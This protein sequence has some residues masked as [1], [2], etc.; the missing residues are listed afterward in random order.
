MFCVHYSFVI[1]STQQNLNVFWIRTRGKETCWAHKSS[2]ER[3]RA[4]LAPCRDLQ[5]FTFGTERLLDE[6]IRGHDCVLGTFHL[7][8]IGKHPHPKQT[9]VR[10]NVRED[11][12]SHLCHL[13]RVCKHEISTFGITEKDFFY[14]F[15]LCLTGKP[16]DVW[17]HMWESDNGTRLSLNQKMIRLNLEPGPELWK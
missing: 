13:Q 1:S 6:R 5:D 2:N 16:E 10:F 9:V 3:S 12:S 17:S 11:G 14:Y 7:F 15:F 8:L 4:A